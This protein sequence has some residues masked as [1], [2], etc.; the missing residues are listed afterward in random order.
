ML[1]VQDF[2]LPDTHFLLVPSVLELTSVHS[3]IA[4]MQRMISVHIEE[5]RT[6]AAGESDLVCDND[7]TVLCV[8]L[9]HHYM[10]L[11]QI[12]RGSGGKRLS[13]SKERFYC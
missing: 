3:K 1:K 6:N 4:V 9:K 7:E 12:T 11:F 8:V 5:S 13:S 10:F 2:T